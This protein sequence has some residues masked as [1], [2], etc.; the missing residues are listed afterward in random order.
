M[1][2]DYIYRLLTMC[3]NDT[4]FLFQI[5]Q[6]PSGH[7][8]FLFFFF[9][10]SSSKTKNWFYTF[11]ARETNFHLFISLKWFCSWV[12]RKC[13]FRSPSRDFISVIYN[14]VTKYWGCI[15]RY[16]ALSLANILCFGRQCSWKK[17]EK[18]MKENVR[19]FLEKFDEKFSSDGGTRGICDQS[20]FDSVF[21]LD[22]VLSFAVDFWNRS[23]MFQQ[24]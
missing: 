21:G 4:C 14:M 2:T 5:K 3:K 10:F 6:Q 22:C 13:S 1:R 8:A 15:K 24:I 17:A 16:S 9:S 12:D 20:Q 23:V 11:V 19:I 7:S 18:K